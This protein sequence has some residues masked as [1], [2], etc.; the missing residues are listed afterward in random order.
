M[1]HKIRKFKDIKP[2]N[3]TDN[4]NDGEECLSCQ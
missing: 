1:E 2:L 3:Q 4:P